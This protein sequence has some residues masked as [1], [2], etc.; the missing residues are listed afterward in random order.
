[1]QECRDIWVLRKRQKYVVTAFARHG[2]PQHCPV[3][4]MTLES[5]STALDLFL[6]TKRDG[7]VTFF[8]LDSTDLVKFDRGI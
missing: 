5:V 2:Q 6:R 1:M 8:T 4:V 7:E 3:M